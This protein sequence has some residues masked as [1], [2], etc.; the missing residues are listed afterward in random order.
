MIPIDRIQPING[1]NDV[2]TFPATAEISELAF[3]PGGLRIVHSR[4]G[5]WPP[6]SIDGKASADD[7]QEATLWVILQIN[8]DWVG[9]GMERL[10]P[11]QTDK[12]E[13]DDPLG[14]VSEWVSGRNFGPFNG[15]VIRN[16]DPIGFM[17]VAGSTR[18]GA[19]F[20]VKERSKVI[21]MTYPPMM[22]ARPVWTEGQPEAPPT[23]A[24]TPD[25]EA[26]EKEHTP[27]KPRGDRHPAAEH[28]TD[29]DLSHLATK[30]DLDAAK[31]EILARIDKLEEGVKESIRQF[32]PALQRLGG[33]FG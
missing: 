31:A 8:G 32:A 18:L 3:R 30:A 29:I 27:R 14:F 19:M 22:G 17:V 28:V 21:E 16:G 15:H 25:T 26:P 9:A 10:R 23:R 6:V 1:P 4:Q 33:L 24:T 13:P 11:R 12:P 20:T 5:L 2:F 7:D